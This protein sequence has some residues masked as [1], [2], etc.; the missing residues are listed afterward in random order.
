[1]S[2]RC[3]LIVKIGL[4]LTAVGFCLSVVT[5]VLAQLNE[6]G[7]ISIL[8]TADG[9]NMYVSYATEPHG[10]SQDHT[11]SQ[12]RIAALGPQDPLHFLCGRHHRCC[13]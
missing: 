6:H 1:M 8:T 4:G 11:G 3:G 9:A 2:K 7:T 10:V 12:V 13:L 5:P